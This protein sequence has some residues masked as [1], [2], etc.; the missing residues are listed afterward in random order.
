MEDPGFLVNSRIMQTVMA[1]EV[2]N[3]TRHMQSTI[4]FG[5]GYRDIWNEFGKCYGEFAKAADNRSD[6]WL[7]EGFTSPDTHMREEFGIHNYDFK[8]GGVDWSGSSR[9]DGGKLHL[10]GR[11][12]GQAWLNYFGGNVD[13]AHKPNRTLYHLMPQAFDYGHSFMGTRNSWGR[14]QGAKEMQ[15]AKGTQ[16]SAFGFL[17]KFQF[18]SLGNKGQFRDLFNHF[19]FMENFNRGMSRLSFRRRHQLGDRSETMY[20]HCMKEGLDPRLVDYAKHLVTLTV[21][22]ERRMF[23]VRVPSDDR[24][25]AD[26]V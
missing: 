14:G 21:L 10:L 8:T 16:L 3:F 20:V 6:V 24:G 2:D 12:Q 26:S 7:S 4:S 13:N 1:Q 5:E 17:L 23:R 18:G 15:G 25:S 11:I 22:A 9:G 19:F